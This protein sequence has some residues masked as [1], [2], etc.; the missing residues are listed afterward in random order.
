MSTDTQQLASEI[1]AVAKML[2]ISPSTVGERAG[3]GGKFYERL[4]KGVK[5]KPVRVWP[6][7]AVKVRQ[8]LVDMQSEASEKEPCDISHVGGDDAVQE[9]G[10]K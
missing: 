3:Q 10:A 6:E 4:T 7:T 1:E 8:R 9:G 2:G 5:G